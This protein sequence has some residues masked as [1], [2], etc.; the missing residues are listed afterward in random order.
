MSSPLEK[1]AEAFF[2]E[3]EKISFKF[4]PVAA[5]TAFGLGTGAIKAVGNEYKERAK[6]VQV[7]LS[8]AQQKANRSSRMKG[9]I[10]STVGTGLVGGGLGYMAHRQTSNIQALR[11][12]MAK[13]DT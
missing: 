8:A 5:S 4:H 10:L 13:L 3:L 1:Q 9:H 2:D 6:D 12:A 7:G 11:E